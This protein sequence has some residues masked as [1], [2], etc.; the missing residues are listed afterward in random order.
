[1]KICVDGKCPGVKECT[2]HCPNTMLEETRNDAILEMRTI[3][4]KG[5]SITNR[6]AHELLLE[7]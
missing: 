5:V 7:R 2:A 4:Q 6:A 1:M 3:I